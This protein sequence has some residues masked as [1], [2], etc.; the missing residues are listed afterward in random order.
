MNKKFVATLALVLLVVVSLTAAPTFSGRFRQ[1]YKFTFAEGAD[2]TITAWKTEEAK[3]VMKIADENGL[4]T[5]N[6]KATGNL[7]SND[8]WS[9]NA[10]VNLGKLLGTA[11]LDL[12][13]F[14]IVASIGA[15]T[16]MTALSAYND[17]TGNELYKL[18]ND[19]KESIQLAMNYGK[20]VKFNVA[21]DPTNTG[22]SLVVSALVAPVDGVSVSVGY[23]HNATFNNTT[24]TAKNVIGGAVNVD[25]AKLAG[26]DFKLG[27][28]AYDN[29]AL[30]ENNLT[31]NTF[32]ANVNGG[33]KE[34]DGFVEFVMLNEIANS[35]TSLYGLNTQ[36]NLNLVKNLGLDVYFNIAD[37]T[38]VGDTFTVGGDASYKLSGVEFAMNLEY[39]KATK[40]FSVTPKVIIVF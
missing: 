17:V 2:P 13:D 12:G 26:L 30:K 10:S 18:R 33:V 3:L 23:A 16:R 4:W 39:A 21:G 8:K 31:R 40:A 14:G 7:D 9:A 6:F 20:L 19:G 34:V 24:Y 27:V 11:G 1:G 29:Y 22:R 32:A 15:N 37:L 38:K 5:V 25:V 28:S 36:V 35:T